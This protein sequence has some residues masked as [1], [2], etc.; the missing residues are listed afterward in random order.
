MVMPLN[1]ARKVRGLPGGKSHVHPKR[2]PDP[3]HLFSKVKAHGAIEW[4]S[5]LVHAERLRVLSL[6]IDHLPEGWRLDDSM[7]RY[8]ELVSKLSHPQILKQIELETARGVARCSIVA[9]QLKVHS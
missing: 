9:R 4:G 1:R 7:A 3:K 6:E 5:A 8:V 2:G